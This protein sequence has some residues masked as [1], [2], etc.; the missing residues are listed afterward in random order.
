MTKRLIIILFLLLSV[1]LLCLS[2]N[3]DKDNLL[4]S[5]VIQYGQ[6]RVNIP[7]PRI[8]EFN[9]L[10]GNVSVS[11]VRK[12]SV[13]IVLSPLT[14]E[15]FISQKFDYKILERTDIKGIITSSDVKQAMEWDSYPTYTQY[16]SIMHSFATLYP[17]L[18][19]LDTIGKTNYNKNVLVLKISDN[20]N[21]NEAEPEVFYTSTIHGDETG[22]FILMLRLADYLLKNYG[23]ISRVTN[24]VDNLQIWINPLANP[25]GMYR[26]GNTISSPIRFNANG[27]DLNRNFPDPETPNT[28]KQK[29]T[30]DMMKFMREHHFVISAN[31]H[32]GDEVVNYPWDRWYRLHADNDWFYYISRNY[33][34]TVHLYSPSAYMNEFDN[35]VTNGYDWYKING[36]RQDFMTWELQGREVTIELDYN[37]VTPVANLNSLWQYNWRSLLGYIENAM[38][39]VHGSVRDSTTGDP[40]PAKIFITGHDKDSSQVY[41]DTLTGNFVRLLSAGTWDLGFSAKGY[42]NKTVNVLVTDEQKTEINVDMVPKL[43]PVDTVTK[44][45]LLYP[46]PAE[47]YIKAVLPDRQI[48]KINVGIYNSTGLK[49]TDYSVTT[50]EDTPLLIN[51]KGLTGGI[52][53][54]VITNSATNVTDKSQFV[55]VRR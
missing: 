7:F 43:N 9:T 47:E 41:S 17:S 38:Y 50:T 10:S 42:Y 49:L 37:F 34:D 25:D 18:C 26:T 52:Y 36:G 55:V 19:R 45:L 23:T 4:R 39:G 27:Y 14:V 16:D 8:R 54:L 21:L 12:E 13:E 40:I 6:A 31:F 11:S 22:G 24:L 51:V 28:V 46:N 35:G 5:E 29:E 53:S 2:Q 48:G 32:S 33:A 15:W 44:T 30:I 20:P 1:T 3:S